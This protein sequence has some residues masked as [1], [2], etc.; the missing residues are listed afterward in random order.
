MAFILSSFSYFP[1][2]M[3]SPSFV[4][5]VMFLHEFD[6]TEVSMIVQMYLFCTNVQILLFLSVILLKLVEERN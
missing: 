5:L 3:L 6:D 2:I 1:N 4:H